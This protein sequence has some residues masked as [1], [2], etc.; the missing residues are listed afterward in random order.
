MQL[1]KRVKVLHGIYSC[2]LNSKTTSLPVRR[3]YTEENESS[4][5]SKDVESLW[6]RYLCPGMAISIHHHSQAPH[7]HTHTLSNFEPS[8]ATRVRLPTISVGW[9]RSSKIFS[10]TSVSVLVRGRFCLTRDVRVGFRNILRWATKTTWRSENFFSS[11]L[12]SLKSQTHSVPQNSCSVTG[13]STH[14]G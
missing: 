3:R 8:T 1:E 4:L 14:L 7:S 12:V 9:T 6:S 13:I 2:D 10:C 11:S 5:Y